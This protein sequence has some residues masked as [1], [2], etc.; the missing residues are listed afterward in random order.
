MGVLA[1]LPVPSLIRQ[2]VP[3][4]RLALHLGLWGTYMATGTSLVL[5]GGPLLMG[6]I[7]WQGLWVALAAMKPLVL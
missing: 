7:G 1:V 6:A 3:P 4:S 2:L 5:A